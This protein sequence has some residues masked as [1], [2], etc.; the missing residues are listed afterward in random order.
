MD[1]FSATNHG[2][3]STSYVN[4]IDDFSIAYNEKE[5]KETETEDLNEQT[6]EEE[7]KG[8]GNKEH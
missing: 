5:V 3:N 6:E 8:S 1:N 4:Y 7:W 2:S